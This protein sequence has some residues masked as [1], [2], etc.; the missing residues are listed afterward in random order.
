M[1]IVNV[2]V[3][4]EAGAI[5]SIKDAVAAMET[6]SRKEPGCHTYAFSVDVNDPTTVRITEHWESR[7]DL[8]NHFTLPHMASFGAALGQ[9]NI[10]SME[11]KAFEAGEEVPLPI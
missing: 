5:E 10:L 2:K 6:E 1:V 7:A 4:V 11:G 3:K 8:Q 9:I